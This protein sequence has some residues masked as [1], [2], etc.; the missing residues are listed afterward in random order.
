M[1]LLYYIWTFRI[2]STAICDLHVESL[3]GQGTWWAPTCLAQELCKQAFPAIATSH[4]NLTVETTI[5]KES[6]CCKAVWECAHACFDKPVLTG[7][8]TSVEA[9]GWCQL[10][11]EQGPSLDLHWFPSSWGPLVPYP[12][13]WDKIYAATHGS[14]CGWWGFQSKPFGLQSKPFPH[15]AIFLP[16]PPEPL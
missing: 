4:Q 5:R 15:R 13:C 9:R 1:Q 8:C 2:L 12:Q 7:M 16:P 14:L 3:R 6:L 11:S 10:S